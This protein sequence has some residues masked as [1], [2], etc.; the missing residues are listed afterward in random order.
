M[1][2]DLHYAPQGVLFRLL[3][4]QDEHATRPTSS[5]RDAN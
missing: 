5:N 4:I 2:L 1:Q 3:K